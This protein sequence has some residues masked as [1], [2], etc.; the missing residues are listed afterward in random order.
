MNFLTSRL[1]IIKL[2]ASSAISLD[3][4]N[5]GLSADICLGGRGGTAEEKAISYNPK[6]ELIISVHSTFDC[7]LCNA[8]TAIHCRMVSGVYVV[9]LV[10]KPFDNYHGQNIFILVDLC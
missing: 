6:Y 2:C 10:V 8:S 3:A 9:G 7:G 1:I 5:F 4:A